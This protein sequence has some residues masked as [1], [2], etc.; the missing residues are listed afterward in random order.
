MKSLIKAIKIVG[1]IFFI[2]MVMVVMVLVFSLGKQ[3]IT[4]KVPSVAG[5]RMYIVL[6][7]SMNPA[8]D[9]GSLVFVKPTSPDKIKD[10][11][12]IT[13]KGF[14][15]QEELV[16]HRV[17]SVNNTVQ[18]IT[19]T[20]K[21]D[22]NDVIDPTPIPAQ[23]LVGKIILAIPYLGYLMDFIKTKQGVLIFILIPA[24]LLLL[25]ELR[26]LYKNAKARK[27]EIGIE[28]GGGSNEV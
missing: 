19:F 25:Y 27:K 4:G 16:S 14:G 26:N 23:Y 15:D 6:S 1:N 28:K 9:T 10:G 5:F 18:G 22:A 8:F 11:D 21:G 17:V 24:V 12:I 2:I 7:G 3:K 13:F 20:T